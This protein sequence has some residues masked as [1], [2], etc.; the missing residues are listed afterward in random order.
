GRS[1]EE[2]LEG[3]LALAVLAAHAGAAAVRVHD[4]AATVSAVAMAEAVAGRLKPRAAIRGLW[5]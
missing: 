1:V 2:R 3:S 5:D 4:V